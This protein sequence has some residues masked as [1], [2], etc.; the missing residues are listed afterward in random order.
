MIE[1][2]LQV[3]EGGSVYALKARFM[4]RI[5][6]GN[7]TLGYRLIRPDVARKLAF[8][9]HLRHRLRR[10]RPADHGGRSAQLT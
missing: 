5:T 4:Y 6:S 3:F 10:H 1:L 7:L 9:V 8:D 2:N